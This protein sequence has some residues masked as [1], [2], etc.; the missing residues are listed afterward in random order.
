MIF[1]PLLAGIL[2]GGILC[3]CVKKDGGP[4]LKKSET[5]YANFRV[6][7][8]N[9]HPIKS[10]HYFSDSLHRYILEPL[11]ER[12]IDTYEWEPALAEKWEISP[13]GQTFTFY[14]HKDLKWSDGKPL[15]AEDVKFSFEAYKNPQN[16]GLRFSLRLQSMESAEIVNKRKIIFRAGKIHFA[17]FEKVAGMNIIPRHIYQLPPE[18]P[19]GGAVKSEAGASAKTNSAAAPKPNSREAANPSGEP[20]TD[21]LAQ[22]AR[23]K[24]P[25]AESLKTSSGAEGQKPGSESKTAAA[26]AEEKLSRTVIGS[27]PYKV[28]RWLKGKMI[29][30]EQNPFWAG[31]SL[32]RNQG[33]W[34]FKN[35]AFRFFLSELD[36][37]LRLQKGALDFELI[38]PESFEQKTDKPPW[39]ISIKKVKVKNKRPSNQSYI[40]FNLRRPLFQDQRVRQALA[41]LM[42][43]E[44]IKKKFWFNHAQLATGPWYSWSSFAD[45]AVKP[46]EFSPRK[47]KGLLKAAGWRDRDKDGILEKTIEGKN[48]D[49]S[50]SLIYPVKDLEKYITIYQEDLK[51]AGIQ[52]NLKLTDPAAYLKLIY[53]RNFDAVL[54]GTV[55]PS[56]ELDPRPYWH[57]KSEGGGGSNFIGYANPQADKLIEKGERQLDQKERIKTFRELYRLI[58]KDVPC[59]F[60]LNYPY[61]FYGVRARIKRPKPFFNYGIGDQYWSL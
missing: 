55:R 59:V 56:V 39:G 20:E 22:S 9:L 35:I 25:K 3:G 26:I 48:R 57:S 49:F 15:T 18:T 6:E 28:S 41:H 36:V 1:A 38:R 43:R 2:W 34:N 32:P 47:A 31:R 51:Q 53:E 16:G 12:N 50:F 52:A 46:I 8:E 33:K 27:G 7:P 10:R 11:L 60:F 17:N 45:P 23:I 4:Q 58:A 37:L 21:R 40:G 14:L 19:S 44:L 54:K 13:D 61:Q 5:F 24:T 29:V 42:N 30:L